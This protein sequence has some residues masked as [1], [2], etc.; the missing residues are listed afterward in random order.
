M[1]DSGFFIIFGPLNL[2]FSVAIENR[3]ADN[4][5]SLRYRYARQVCLANFYG[6][7]ETIHVGEAVSDNQFVLI[8]FVPLDYV[9]MKSRVKVDDLVWLVD[10][11]S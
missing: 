2:C 7:L 6:V 1:S 10:L 11:E 9:Q 4:N 8:L 5:S 3:V